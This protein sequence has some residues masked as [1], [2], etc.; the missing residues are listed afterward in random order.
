[1]PIEALLKV[2]CLTVA[3]RDF[4]AHSAF[5]MG[6]THEKGCAAALAFFDS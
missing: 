4:L 1:M 3:G 5:C 2:V 6:D